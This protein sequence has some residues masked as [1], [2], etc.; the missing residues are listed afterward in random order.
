MTRSS[1][2]GSGSM[3]GSMSGNG[4]RMRPRRARPRRG[5]LQHCAAWTRSRIERGRD[6]QDGVVRLTLN[7]PDKL[8]AQTVAMW[9]YLARVGS[10]AGRRRLD[11]GPRRGRRTA[12]R[13]RPASTSRRSPLR[14]LLRFPPR[15]DAAADQSGVD[16]RSSRSN[17][18]SSWLEDAPYPTIAKVQGHAFGAGHAVR[19]GVRPADRRRRRAHGP[20]RAQLGS[21]ARP[22]RDRVAPP[23]RRT[24]EGARADAHR[25]RLPRR[26][27]ARAG[28]RQPGGGPG[29]ARRCRRAVRLGAAGASTPRRA[30]ARR[31]R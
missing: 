22:R 1:A 26:R 14:R 8:N 18:R 9:Q 29:R 6:E 31:P 12:G 30:A 17:A 21:H 19:A 24:G 20:A 2:L 7:R 23:S 3:R 10:R 13:S 5:R 28:D 16:W 4:T 25:A 11:S 27:A 15:N